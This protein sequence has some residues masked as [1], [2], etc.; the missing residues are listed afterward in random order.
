MK[1]SAEKLVAVVG[2]I[3]DV[4]KVAQR[5]ILILKMLSHSHFLSKLRSSQ[6][7]AIKTAQNFGHIY[8]SKVKLA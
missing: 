2:K 3:R 1:T 5:A 4:V 7:H 8:A 6:I